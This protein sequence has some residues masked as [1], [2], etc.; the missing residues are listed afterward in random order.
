VKVAGVFSTEQ[1]RIAVVYIISDEEY[2]EEAVVRMFES[3]RPARGD[4]IPKADDSESPAHE[5]ASSNSANEP[6]R[7]E[8]ADD[9]K[10]DS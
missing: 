5:E 2:D 3:I 1:A 4:S 10:P 7:A 6:A 9:D 8:G